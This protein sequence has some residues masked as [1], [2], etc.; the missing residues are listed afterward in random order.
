MFTHETSVKILLFYMVYMT[1]LL[2]KDSELLKMQ[3]IPKCGSVFSPVLIGFINLFLFIPLEQHFQECIS[4]NSKYCLENLIQEQEAEILAPIFVCIF[5]LEREIQHRSNLASSS[6]Q[7][8]YGHTYQSHRI[9]R[10]FQGIFKVLQYHF[11]SRLFGKKLMKT[12]KQKKPKN[13]Q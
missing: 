2:N 8:C 7:F 10:I 12:N 9:Y 3:P 6:V 11:S 4:V 1:F 5:S 13:H